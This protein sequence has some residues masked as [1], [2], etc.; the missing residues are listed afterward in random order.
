M[1]NGTTLFMNVVEGRFSEFHIE[2]A[3]WI[4]SLA[5]MCPL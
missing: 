1:Q 5:N 2:A 4:S 3:G